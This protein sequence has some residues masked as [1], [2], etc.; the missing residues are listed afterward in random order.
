[1]KQVKIIIT[2]QKGGVGKSTIASNLAGYFSAHHH[3]KISFIDFDRQASGATLI[4]KI[5]D[6]NI[7]VYKK[8][9]FFKQGSNWSLIEARQALNTYSV[10]V[11][12]VI[13]DLTWTFGLPYDFLLDFD[14]IVVPSSD[15]SLEVASTE[16]FVLE[17]IQKNMDKLRLI[18]QALVVVPSRIDPSQSEIPKFS[19][20]DFLTNCSVSP[21][22]Y[23]IPGIDRYYEEGFLCSSADPVIAENFLNLGNFI[24]E[25]LESL[26]TLFVPSKKITPNLLTKHPINRTASKIIE[27]PKTLVSTRANQ[28]QPQS[29]ASPSKEFSFIPKF[30]RR[31]KE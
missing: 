8:E 19:G 26:S 13:A 28:T 6:P 24:Y 11:D 23:R 10:G 14:L 31:G 25:K 18:N 15:T 16:I 7:G 20:L 29:Q 12:I 9:L 4:K 30:L 27:Q 2:N 3:K 5:H 21:P 17:Y 22:I 1:M